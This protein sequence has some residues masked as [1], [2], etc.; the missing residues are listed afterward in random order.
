MYYPDYIHWD[1]GYKRCTI[2]TIYTGMVDT[3]DVLSLLYAL[4]W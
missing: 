2:L 1:G 3:K 4:G